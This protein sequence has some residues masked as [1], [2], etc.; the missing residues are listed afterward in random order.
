MPNR[1][2][3]RRAAQQQTRAKVALVRLKD[4]TYPWQ[5]DDKLCAIALQD[6]TM[7]N[8]LQTGHPLHHVTGNGAIVTPD[9]TTEYYLKRLEGNLTYSEQCAATRRTAAERDQRADL[10]A[11][12]PVNRKFYGFDPYE[13]H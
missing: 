3:R 2:Q 4:I 6:R 11:A 8:I 13:R 7:Q 5:M 10:P 1:Y 9:P 12:V